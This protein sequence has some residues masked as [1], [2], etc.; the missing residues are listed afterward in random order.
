MEIFRFDEEVAIPIA[1]FGSRLR[2]GPLTGPDSAVKVQVMYLPARGLIGRHQAV[3]RQLFGVVAGRGWVAG[4][5]GT[6]RAVHSGYA[7]L[8]E[9]GEHHE[10]GSD[11]GLTAICIEGAF[12]MWALRVTREIVVT[13]Y[14]PQWPA[15][16]E[17]VRE[18]V[19]PAVAD[20]ALRIDHVGSTSVTGL[21]AKPIIDMDIVV[22][23][24]GDVPL[25][26]GRLA[27]IGYRWRGDLG[28]AGRQAFE[29]PTEVGLP[30]HQLYLIVENNK[31]HVDH[32]LLRDVLR[33]D[34]GA[35][36]RYATL[37]RRNVEVAGGDMD[38][39]VAAKAQFVA[40]VLTRARK[41]RGL[42][43][44]QYWSPDAASTT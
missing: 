5:D 3:I 41:R 28:V 1:E 21:A 25:A 39:Y 19:W 34:P 12:D 35:R 11:E 30:A 2:I 20:V 6:R 26:I 9:A 8:W 10:A 42:P 27:G 14:D 32:W 33:E 29:P 16:F 40:E 22:R 15:W 37:K 4:T 13:D 36:M 43:P 44:E 38:V 24:E 7:A 23:S 17:Q 31:A 18:R